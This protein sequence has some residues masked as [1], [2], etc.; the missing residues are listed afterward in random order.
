MQPGTEHSQDPY[1]RAYPRQKTNIVKN[2]LE[3]QLPNSP[4]Q[5]KGSPSNFTCPI[6]LEQTDATSHKACGTTFHYYSGAENQYCKTAWNSDINL[7]HQMR[8]E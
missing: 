7:S 5:P 8:V 6:K 2:R 4:V 1:S 3:W